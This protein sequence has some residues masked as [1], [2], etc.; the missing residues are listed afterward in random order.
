MFT[1]LK[2]LQK[3]HSVK[4]EQMKEVILPPLGTRFEINGMVYKVVYQHPNPFKFHAVPVAFATKLEKNI[5]KKA[6]KICS[7]L[8]A[9]LARKFKRG[10][11]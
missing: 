6:Y 5:F 2:I 11:S 8:L 9:R 1:I 7:L 10:N 3:K 4:T